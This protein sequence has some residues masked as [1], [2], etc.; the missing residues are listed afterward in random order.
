MEIPDPTP[1]ESSK[2]V[3]A[4]Y[5]GHYARPI[6]DI[7][8]G[9]LGGD[10]VVQITYKGRFPGQDSPPPALPPM[11]LALCETDRLL[12]LD[13]PFKDGKAEIV[14]NPDGSIGW[15]RI[16]GRIHAREA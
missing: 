10:L 15:L 5:V 11:R 7:E 13:G 3:L 6:A 4:S 14:R 12:V 8:L 16:G 2:E 9:I 1:I